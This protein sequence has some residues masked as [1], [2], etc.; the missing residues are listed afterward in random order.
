[1]Q[2]F[3]VLNCYGIYVLEALGGCVPLEAI[4][5]GSYPVKSVVETTGCR[6]RVALMY[7]SSVHRLVDAS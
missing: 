3:H 1:M 2:A 6:E 5:Q 4:G 7:A